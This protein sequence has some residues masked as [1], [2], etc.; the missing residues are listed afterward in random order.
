[1]AKKILNILLV[2]FLSLVGLW[3]TIALLLTLPPLQNQ[4]RL[5]LQNSLSS[6]LHA[7]ISI[8]E[9]Q[10]F[11]LRTVS[12]RH[13]RIL[14]PDS[15]LFASI[16]RLKASI[17]LS[18][19]WQNRL[20]LSGI[21][22][23]SLNVLIEQT[24]EKPVRF[25]CSFM[26]ET[27][28]ARQDSVET[29]LN[30]SVDDIRITHSNVL[31]KPIGKKS[32]YI[33]NINVHI[34][35]LDINEMLTH[36]DVDRLVANING[37][38]TQIKLEAT[39]Q[40]DTILIEDMESF[41]GQSHLI[42]NFLEYSK[43]HVK[44]SIH[45]LSL[46]QEQNS[47]L[48]GDEYA[49]ERVVLKGAV[50]LNG[51]EI[52]IDNVTGNIGGITAPGSFTINGS[53]SGWRDV[54]KSRASLD[55]SDI[56]IKASDLSPLVPNDMA[57][58]FDSIAGPLSG[59]IKLR[60]TDGLMGLAVNL[61]SSQASFSTETQIHIKGWDNIS[62]DG[63]VNS[64]IIPQN[65]TIKPLGETSINATFTG[66]YAGY[67]KDDTFI[68]FSGTLPSLNIFDYNYHDITIDGMASNKIQN[69]LIDLRD[70]NG[71]ATAII[72]VDKNSDNPQ[73]GLTIGADSLRIGQMNIT[74]TIPESVI[75]GQMRAEIN[76][77]SLDDLSGFIIVN[78][79]TIKG[80]PE[81]I[82]TKE[83]N[84]MMGRNQEDNEK[85]HISINS[86]FLNGK[87]EG[88]F[89]ISHLFDNIS[90]RMHNCAPALIKA[91]R[92]HTKYDN[93]AT[94]DLRYSDIQPYA[95]YID[96]NLL[97]RGNGNI[98][99]VLNSYGGPMSL[100]LSIDTISYEKWKASHLIIDIQMAENDSCNI[101]IASR[102]TYGS[103]FG[104]IGEVK[105]SNTL[106]NN[107][108][109]SSLR[110]RL[111]TDENNELSTH[112]HFSKRNDGEL[113]THVDI[114]SSNVVMSG[115]N[116]AVSASGI[117]IASDAIGIHGFKLSNRER[118][119]SLNGKNSKAN[120]EDTLSISLNKFAI[121]DVLK[122]TPDDKYSL[123]GDVNAL[124]YV[125]DIYGKVIVNCNA[126]IY[127]FYVDGERLDHA[128][129]ETH[130]QPEQQNLDIGM[131]IITR[132][133]LCADAK[134]NLDISQ[135]KM[136]LMFDIDSLSIGWL[137]FYL[138]TSIEDM[139]GTTSGWLRLHGPLD[140]IGLHSRLCVHNSAFR[141]KQTFVDYTID[142]NDSIILSPNNMEFKHMQFTDAYGNHGDFNGNITHNMFSGLRYYIN[143]DTKDLLVLETT[144]KENPIYYGHVFAT[145]RL[146]VR[147]TTAN[148]LLE[149]KA[150]SRGNS[151]FYIVPSQTSDIGET[152]YIH[153]TNKST[154][155]NKNDKGFNLEK[156]LEGVEANLDIDIHQDSRI[157][158]IFD[159][160]TDNRLDVK[161]QGHIGLN[162][163]K[164]GDILMDGS[165]T[166]NS[167]IYNFSF[168][169]IMN[170]RFEIEQ[171]SKVMWNGDP[172][173]AIV[174]LS[175][176]YRVNT[177]L[178][179][180]IGN[181][182]GMAEGADLKK[183]V[184]VLCKLFL[185]EHIMDPNI[186]FEIEIPSSQALN[187]TAINQYLS[188]EEEI[189]RQVF[190][191]LMAGRFYTNE[192]NNANN[193]A[194]GSTNASD[195]IGTTLSELVSN[196]LSSYISQN[197]YNVNLGVN[198]RRGD[199]V[200]NEEYGVNA[201][202]DV[203]GGKIIL[204]GSVGYGRDASAD[205]QKEGNFIGDFDVEVKLN[206]SG[207][208][209]A[210]AYTHS[211]NDVIYE[212]S[213]TTQGIGISYQ[214]SFDHVRELFRKYFGWLRRKKEEK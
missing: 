94:I 172:W 56:S 1:M 27:D 145:G 21:D 28:D 38:H 177:S 212:T 173:D 87:I 158:A 210:K 195:Y 71:N 106:T 88:R 132:G 186:R 152:D 130:W 129:I 136:D 29:S 19:L 7:P 189:N 206:E 144:K 64:S 48:F 73:Y 95:Q 164:Q 63:S 67:D 104:D 43:D 84:I 68:H 126:D 208:L 70:R 4:A 26:I 166:I 131:K 122:T 118:F 205:A 157:I 123:D 69:L 59:H 22:I 139:R 37:I 101:D 18:S 107:R 14:T 2:V 147:G 54:E 65:E 102:E 51:D 16:G 12:L 175:A 46:M 140:N 53:L 170:K 24:N 182:S 77:T 213:P 111:N 40:S 82:K 20:S 209:R 181:S 35:D 85:R 161:G 31:Y 114:D 8:A 93:Y 112:S 33:G 134:G 119:I 61:S 42:L 192:N 9:F 89:L 90:W 115:R 34:T 41:Y 185:T 76:G 165:Y 105:W 138:S 110:W 36:L 91:P 100:N 113:R 97:I 60:G 98:T 176:K 171:G 214:E 197:K 83:I 75:D 6:Q 120:P 184:P 142:G 45:E 191:L 200:M 153:F 187:Q 3:V 179:D 188:T 204:S 198:Y 163:T 108:W 162:I 81:E 23:D 109:D 127:N 190:S 183:N 99:G 86:D 124:A 148:C 133:R 30:I 32:Q 50:D 11:P 167:G 58:L 72:S 201:Q 47:L 149:V 79:L 180:L 125:N 199:D 52:Q 5:Q 203:L 116:W 96:D 178:Y 194:T 10:F 74:P 196:Q 80:K 55:I 168:Q 174:D 17:G 92:Q 121:S 39:Y 207:T 57:N 156:Q 141:V 137:N 146:G 44:T 117:D 151:E 66:L 25:N 143:F 128:S 13:I 103:G 154:Y 160:T 202:T 78:N 211:N 150:Q 135:N 193:T 49:L 159:P 155:D 62:F 15:T 169:H